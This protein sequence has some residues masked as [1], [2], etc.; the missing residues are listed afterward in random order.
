MVAQVFANPL[1]LV[2]SL[3]ADALEQLRLAD[4]GQLEELW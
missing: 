3:D 2:A 1:Q 4:A